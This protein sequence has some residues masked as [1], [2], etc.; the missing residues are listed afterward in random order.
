MTRSLRFGLAAVGLLLL[1]LWSCRDQQQPVAPGPEPTADGVAPLFARSDGASGGNAHFFFLP[2]MVAAPSFSGVFDATLL[3]LLRV[4]VCRLSGSA[5]Q[6]P[7]L[8]SFT[9]SGSSAYARIRM[10]AVRQFYLV[11]WSTAGLDATPHYRVSVFAGQSPLGFADVDVVASSSQ[12]PGVNRSQFVGVVRGQYLPIRFR[13]EQGA[14]VTN[15]APT[16]VITAPAEGAS[17][18]VGSSVAFTG[19]ASD[20]EQGNL[21]ASIQWSLLGGGSLGSGASISTATLGVGAH[22]IVATVTDNGGLSDADTVGIVITNTAPVVTITAP[23]DGSTFVQGTNVT[24]TGTAM[25]AESGDLSAGIAWSSNLGGALGTGASI[26]TS[27]LAPGTHRIVASRSDPQGLAGAD[28]ITVVIRTPTNQPPT[29]TITAPP[30]GSSFPVGSSINFTG[31]ASDPEQGNLT[32]GIQWSVLGGGALGAGASVS[33]STLGVG[34]R[35]IVASITDNGGLTDTDTVSV[36]ITNTAPVVTITAP[37]DGSTFT[38]GVSVT[39]TGTA[40]DAES[41]NL[42]AGIAWSSNLAGGLGTGASISTSA[43]GVGTHRII[44]SRADPQGLTGADTIQV[45]IGQPA[46]R[47]PTVTINAP[48]N[49]QSALQG[50]SIQFTGSASDPEQGTLSGAA[51]VWTSSVAG[52]I[53]TGT[54]FTRNNLAV[55]THLI[56]LVATDAGGL[57]D[58]AEVTITILPTG[59]ISIPQTTSMG[60][61][62]TVSVPITISQPAQPGGA[63]I[64]LTSSDTNIVR[65]LTP[66]LFIPEGATLAN[67]SVRGLLPGSVT[68]T[69]SSPQFG[70]AQGQALVTAGLNILESNLNLA[71]TGSVPI[72]VQLE[73]GGAPVVA[74]PGGLA[75][76]LT[77]RN[78]ACVAA[79]ATVTIPANVV[80]TTATVSHGGGALPC[81][82]FVVASAGPT[83]GRDSIPVN[84]GAAI[85][86]Q[87]FE[88]GAGLMARLDLGLSTATHGG[89]TVKLK[90]LDPARLR[91]SPNNATA[92]TDS[93][94]VPVPNGTQSV[95]V[96]VHG[97]EG[98]TGSPGLQ[99]TAPGFG[100]AN[101]S[102]PLFQP[103]IQL[104]GLPPT[105][106]AVSANSLIFVRVGQ[107]V[108]G[109]TAVSE[110]QQVRAGSAGIPVTVTHTNASAA[111]LLGPGGQVGQ[112]INVT[113]AAGQSRTPV[114]NASNGGME[115]DPLAV[116]QDTVRVSTPGLIGSPPRVAVSITGSQ[117][118]IGATSVGAGLMDAT[119]VNLGASGHGGVTV[120]IRSTDPARLRVSPNA[121]TAGTDS[122]LIPVPNGTQFVNVQVHG[123]EGQTGAVPVEA[124]APGFTTGSG[125][126]TVVQPGI[127]VLGIPATTTMVSTNSQF[128]VRV[129][130]PSGANTSVGTQAV[131]AGSPGLPITVTN[132]NAAAARLLGPGGQVGQ[133][134][135]I[136]IPAGQSQTAGGGLELDP[137]GVGVDTV[138]ASAA[139]FV[140]SPGFQAT[141]ITGAQII[142]A[143]TEVGAGL[144]VQTFINLGASGHGGVTLKIRSTNPAR[145]RVG[146]NNFATAGTDS[147][148]LSV[149]NG[150]QFVNYVVHG[151]EGGTGAVPVVASAPGFSTGTAPIAVVQAGVQVL[152]VPTGTTTQSANTVILVRVGTPTSGS[153][154]V[155]E[156]PLRTGGPGAAFTVTNSNASAARLLGPGGQV[157]QTI[158][159]TIAAGQSRTPVQNAA[160][161]GLEFDPL[162]VGVDTVRASA[163]GFVG[164]PGFQAST[165]SVPQFAPSAVTVGS[166]LMSFAF[167]QIGLAGTGLANPITVKVKSNNPALFRV[168]PNDATA[169][170]DSVLI[171]VPAGQASVSFFVHGMD[172]VTVPTGSTVTLSAPG[173]LDGS[174]TVTVVQPVVELAGLLSPIAAGAANRNFFPRVGVAQGQNFATEQPRRAGAAPLTVTLT[175]S[176]AGVARLVTTALT[177][178]TV[179]VQIAARESRTG[180]VANG[181]IDF[182]PLAA[183]TTVVSASI[184]GFASLPTATRTVVVN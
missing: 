136:T 2:P 82:T 59:T 127:E 119:S 4:E 181:G 35:Q 174:A 152:S 110:T 87:G 162:G 49:G 89:T 38:Q 58:T 66:T 54:S 108:G 34:A 29:V 61:G 12:L 24:F 33:T 65:V 118:T 50:A 77:S 130:V 177:G 39:F 102:F 72:T 94:L 36:V 124:S 176:Q 165:I 96:F 43:L 99:V 148:L 6:S 14:I 180:I 164:S 92:G 22:Q 101:A 107:P 105:T 147:V 115:Y 145:L 47:P 156:Q 131:R 73:F 71:A 63:A 146:P 64:T 173:F 48:G 32:A 157:G 16:V 121:A 167:A 133:T 161:G 126:V 3:G 141:T 44:A 41:G 117:I 31:T 53:G 69:A 25:D 10:D 143:P 23:P 149:P 17:F 88:L 56:R 139:G 104:V 70:S 37:P 111:R 5:C 172:G 62:Q 113:I 153:A 93:I 158:N 79:P 129:G 86:V 170:T 9:S 90:S 179:T 134:V 13:V 55:G 42:S 163:A 182:D 81:N 142:V 75:V 184:P 125:T 97:I 120:K 175:N 140:P 171:A 166:G 15:T 52:Q 51:L 95:S 74:P 106:T 154:F 27:T 109:N 1:L 28:T 103:G 144:M 123:V 178:Q 135:N 26:S 21:S 76:T 98:Q 138:R 160:N 67:A 7:P 169:G 57:A 85:S 45:T 183:G 19:T 83:I 114:Q 132:S 8:A 84:V 155:V 11:Y 137:L 80:S 112:T 18:P 78:P 30:E 100:T 60:L 168:S 40:M 46:N 20:A 116:G 150:T 68:L 151:I 128:I 122:V 159:V 91:V